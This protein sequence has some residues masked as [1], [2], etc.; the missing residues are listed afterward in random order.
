MI[1]NWRRSTR[2]SCGEID[3]CVEVGSSGGVVGYRD[4]KHAALPETERPVLLVPATAA[5]ALLKM[6]TA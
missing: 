2:C 1:T 5:R 3:A 4:T 6:I